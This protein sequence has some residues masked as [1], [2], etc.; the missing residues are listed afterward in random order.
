[1]NSLKA[2]A[3][4][5]AL[6]DS[7]VGM[8]LSSTTTVAN[9]LDPFESLLLWASAFLLVD[10]L[11]CLYGVHYAFPVAAVLGA[12]LAGDSLLVLSGYT[13]QD[14]VLV[15][16]SASGLVLNLLAYRS[17]S[18]ISEQANPMNLPVFG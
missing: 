8:Y 12:V 1:M 18:Q 16:L 15:A 9:N 11:L 17:T 13:L 14:A 10:S 7:V 6:I 4:A 3:G 5:I 2:T